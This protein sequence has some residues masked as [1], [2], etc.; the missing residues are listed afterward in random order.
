[1]LE[2]KN[3][4]KS[5]GK[6]NILSDV[7][8]SLEN[9]TAA[10]M[11]ESGSG[12][13]TLLRMIAGLEKPDGGE[14]SHDGKIAV[15]F[16]EPRLFG[17]VSVLCN[18]TAAMTGN[19]TADDKKARDILAALGLAGTEDLKPAELSS[20][21]AQRVSLARAV[22]SERDI[23]LLDEPT[24]N[25]DDDAK[26]AVEDYLRGFLKGKTALVVTH[27]AAQAQRLCDVIYYIAD[28]KISQK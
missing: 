15:A 27:D 3:V 23:Y 4:S 26:A 2:I 28:G 24:S 20:G 13:T 10:L 25:L 19:T 6:K 14:I 9:Q 17:N 7:S 12:K 16:A 22:A 21:M 1:M 5:F 11:G 8:F 18:V